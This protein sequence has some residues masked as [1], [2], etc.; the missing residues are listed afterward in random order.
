M[1]QHEKM[2]KEGGWV[3]EDEWKKCVF[4]GGGEWKRTVEQ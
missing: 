1:C 2:G 3:E 4:E